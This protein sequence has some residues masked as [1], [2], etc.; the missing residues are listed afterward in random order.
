MLNLYSLILGD[1]LM[2]K[3]I[4]AAPTIIYSEVELAKAIAEIE[5]LRA[6][7]NA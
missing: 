7:K 6:E 1:D 5:R 3:K 2:Q 4:Q